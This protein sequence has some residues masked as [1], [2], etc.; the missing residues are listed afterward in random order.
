MLRPLIIAICLPVA[1]LADPLPALICQG[2]APD[3]TL[4][5]TD[6]QARFDFRGLSEMDIPQRAQAQGRDWPWAL[7]LIGPRDSAIAIID[8]RQCNT[9]NYAAHVLT[10]QGEVPIMLT[11]CCSPAP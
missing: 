9:T 1:A 2:T 10:Q 11:G 6:T 7:T 8:A 5:L 3:W 4:E